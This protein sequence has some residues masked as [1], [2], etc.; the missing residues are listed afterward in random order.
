[1]KKYIILLA[2]SLLIGCS[3][4]DKNGF[5]TS[6]RNE[7]FHSKTRTKFDVNGYT[8]D[9]YDRHGFNKEGNDREGYNRS[10]YSKFGV[11]KEGYDREGYN[12]DGVNRHGLDKNN[13]INYSSLIR[14]NKTV[15]VHDLRREFEKIRGDIADIKHGRGENEFLNSE[16]KR[17]KIIKMIENSRLRFPVLIESRDIRRELGYNADKKEATLEYFKRTDGRL[18]GLQV[19]GKSKIL[20]EPEHAKN[21]VRT[22]FLIE[23]PI[24]EIYKKLESSTYD[25]VDFRQIKEYSEYRETAYIGKLL[26]S[27]VEYRLPNS[28]SVRIKGEDG[29]FVIRQ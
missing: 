4:V 14:R 6:G 27:A 9:G 18:R 19:D 11:D 2:A 29:D 20:I 17:E 16:K 15:D 3:S 13:K 12:R 5:Y 21:I 7:N 24:I 10:G 8:R 28:N 23:T 26:Y 22:F 1:M 25:K